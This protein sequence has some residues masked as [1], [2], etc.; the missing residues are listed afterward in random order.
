MGVACSGY[1]DGGTSSS[2]P[3]ERSVVS[4]EES[5]SSAQ[6]GADSESESANSESPAVDGTESESV[7]EP[8]V[9]AM[10]ELSEPPSVEEQL[11]LGPVEAIRLE[12]CTAP[13]GV[14]ASPRDIGQLVA[15][16]NSLPLPTTLACLVASLR[17]PLGLF[18]TFGAASAQPAR[19][20]RSPRTFLFSGPFIFSIVPDEEESNIL[21][22]GL[23]ISS[24]RSVKGEL[25]FPLTQELDTTELE[26]R[27]QL[28]LTGTVCGGCHGPEIEFDD[29]FYDNAFES[30]ILE[31]DLGLDA[32]LASL[33]NFRDNCDP[34]S[35]P[36]RCELLSAIFDHGLIR[37]ED[38]TDAV[39]TRSIQ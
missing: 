26:R 8:E 11:P 28:G 38:F 13:A 36:L 27:S 2:L 16:L 5:P 24:T 6:A 19:G 20:I 33:R 17:R 32:S 18:A 9:Q 34:S 23:L 29:P 4:T 3:A 37:A 10:S 15:L 39:A 25:E 30:S 22:F 1:A 12:T 35:E 14:S 31:P 7:R 21:E